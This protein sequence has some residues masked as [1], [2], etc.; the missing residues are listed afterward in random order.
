MKKQ[1]AS[2]REKLLNKIIFLLEREYGIPEKWPCGEA[3]DALIGTIL[4]QNT[5]DKNRD[6]AH[7]QL[8]K[9]YKHDYE[10]IMNAPASAL[11]KTIRAGGLANIKAKR[12]KETLHTIKQKRGK[13]DLSFLNDLNVEQ[14]RS[15]MRSL[16]G[17][18]PK[19]AA[20]VLHFCF[21][22]PTFPIDTHIFRIIKRLELV[23]ESESYE[24]AHGLMEKIVPKEKIGSLH[25]NLI[26][27]GRK[28]CTAKNP[29][30]AECVLLKLCKYGKKI[31]KKKK[32]QLKW[33]EKKR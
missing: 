19:T 33:L 12:I 17:V 7:A 20:V 11:A 28:I 6:K 31:G 15:F 2:K 9:R 5:N 27:H 25:L 29:K 21:D 8:D 32:E 13:I 18:G 1:T 24:R 10:S 16:P 26:A 4:S 30:C 3:V 14:S 22:R 23:E